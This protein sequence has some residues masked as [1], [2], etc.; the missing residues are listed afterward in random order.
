MQEMILAGVGVGDQWEAGH[1][2]P[3]NYV[4]YPRRRGPQVKTC[5]T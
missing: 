3:E 1:E 5:D 2:K 4:K